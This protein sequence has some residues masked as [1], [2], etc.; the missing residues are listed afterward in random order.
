MSELWEWINKRWPVREAFRMAVEEDIA[1]GSSF[2]YS[3]GASLLF[4]FALQAVTGVFQMFYYVPTTDYAYNSVNYLRISVPFGWLIHGLH[5]WGAQAMVILVVVHMTRVFIWG[6][7]KKPRELT[8]LLGTFLFLTVMAMV[9][10]GALLPWDEKGYYAAEVGTSIAGTVP[11]IGDFVKRVMRGGESMGQLTL[12]RFFIT[13]IAL[14]PGLLAALAGLHVV[15]FRNSGNVGPWKEEKRVR[16]GKFWPEQV[17]KDTVVIIVILMALVTLVVFAPAPISG[18]ADPIDTSYNPKPEWN[19]LSLYQALKVFKGPWEPVGTVGLPLVVGLILLLIPFVDRREERNPFKRPVA[20]TFMVV[21]AAA[22]ITLT[23]TGAL[24]NPSAS[25]AKAHPAGKTQSAAV[26]NAGAQ[27]QAVTDTTGAASK[28]AA[29]TVVFSSSQIQTGKRLVDSLGCRACHTIAGSGGK[30]GPNLAGEASRG[31]DANWIVAQIENPKA[32]DPSTVM[33]AFSGLTEAHYR[34]IA[35]YILSLKLG[36]A[37]ES[38][39]S[40]GQVLAGAKKK[41]VGAHG[42]PGPAAYILGNAEHGAILFKQQCQ[43]CHGVD[44]KGGKPNPGSNDGTIP[45]LNPID[46]KIYNKNA[47]IFAEHV[48]IRL[49]HGAIPRGPNPEFHMPDFGDSHSMTQQ[50]IAEV[51]TYVLSLND[52]KRAQIEHPGIKPHLF[53][54]ISMAAFALVIVIVG[55]LSIKARADT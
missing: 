2:F 47:Q 46:P 15:A 55:S 51:I 7:Y 27:K 48:D 39:P 30:V 35:G 16:K 43:H 13:H 18:P 54:W 10:T 31:H 4:V 33:P 38:T 26:S 50:E 34:D 1:G 42:Q 23:I 49:Q 17:T 29:D 9:F 14:I 19:F 21:A 5:Y 12:S 11:W 41:I 45:P 25:G 6:A 28:S 53:W 40:A 3:V 32:H 36:S 44:A 24:S 8:W 20:M 37:T 52:V 22:V